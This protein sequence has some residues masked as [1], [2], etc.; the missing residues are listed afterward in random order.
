MNTKFAIEK[1]QIEV[2]IKA[3]REFYLTQNE[4]PKDCECDDCAYFYNEFIN[5]TSKTLVLIQSFGVD[6]GKNLTSEPTG[7][8]CV[9]DESGKVAHIFQVYQMCGKLLDI[10]KKEFEYSSIENEMKM[11]VK[12]IQS[13]IDK[14]DIELTIGEE[15]VNVT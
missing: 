7:V 4:I 6:L 1:N 13:A 11:N 9:R 5:M 8:W 10:N 3:T 2:D 12:F 14:I 15:N